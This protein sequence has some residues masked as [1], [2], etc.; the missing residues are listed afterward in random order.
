MKWGY[1]I[2]NEYRVKVLTKKCI[3]LY[4]WSYSD[5][6]KVEPF[7]REQAKKLDLELRWTP[8]SIER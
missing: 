4:S 6:D 2:F 8:G 3:K 5:R 7:A 1:V